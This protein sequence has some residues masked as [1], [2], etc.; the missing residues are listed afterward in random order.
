[1][2]FKIFNNYKEFCIIQEKIDFFILCKKT[3]KAIVEPYYHYFIINEKN[4][5]KKY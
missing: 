1:M 5:I 2:L 3:Y 4:S